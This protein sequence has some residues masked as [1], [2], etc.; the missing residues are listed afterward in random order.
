MEFYDVN[1][2]DFYVAVYHLN[3]PKFPSKYTSLVK[4]NSSEKY[5]AIPKD[6]A[7]N[8]IEAAKKYSDVSSE[9][10][11]EI[12]SVATLPSVESAVGIADE[13]N[14]L[15]TELIEGTDYILIS[16]RNKEMIDKL[17]GYLTDPS[18]LAISPSL[19]K[20]YIHK[21]ENGIE[22]EIVPVSI[23][24]SISIRTVNNTTIPIN[25]QLTLSRYTTTQQTEQKIRK[26]IDAEQIESI[27]GHVDVTLM[28]GDNEITLESSLNTL[29]S[30]TQQ[31]PKLNAV[32]V[33][34]K[35]HI[36]SE[37]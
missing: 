27:P 33:E 15:K 17:Y 30:N 14:N 23:D 22:K 3:S 32:A 12:N 24:L 7:T 36:Y 4:L 2:S 29:L 6:Y 16:K 20:V 31:N 13:N 19:P 5:Y 10:R 25:K 11:D 1:Y 9:D 35:T 18:N 28:D 37:M 26:I 21:G 8:L 34:K